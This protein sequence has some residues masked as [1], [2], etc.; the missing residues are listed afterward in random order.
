MLDEDRPVDEMSYVHTGKGSLFPSLCVEA[1]KIEVL[2]PSSFERVAPNSPKYITRKP[3][4]MI[5][6]ST[7]L[8]SNLSWPIRPSSDLL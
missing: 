4:Q 5:A 6:L 2:V 1:L 3:L 8:I 7:S